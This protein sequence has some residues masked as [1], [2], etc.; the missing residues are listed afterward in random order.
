[1]EEKISDGSVVIALETFNGS[2][3]RVKGH[4]MWISRREIKMCATVKPH[5]TKDM[6]KDME[7]AKKRL[8]ASIS[9]NITLSLSS[10][11]SA[12]SGSASGPSELKKRGST[13]WIKHLIKRQGVN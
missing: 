9:R 3:S 4:L 10:T 2:Y 11:S 8:K 12:A 5:N 7:Q 1:M 6:T 13:L